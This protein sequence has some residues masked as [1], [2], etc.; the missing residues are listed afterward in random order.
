MERQG[1]SQKRRLLRRAHVTPRL[2]ACQRN[3]GPNQGCNLEAGRAAATGLGPK[4]A[5]TSSP[6]RAA[7]IISS[8]LLTTNGTPGWRACQRMKARTTM[9]G[10]S[11]A[12][13]VPGLSIITANGSSTPTRP[14]RSGPLP[15]NTTPP[16]EHKRGLRALGSPS[17]RRSNFRVVKRAIPCQ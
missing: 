16:T 8:C 17:L 1:H 11:L 15:P 13:P 10:R 14:G 9:S 4:P 6:Q 7:Q 5:R 12:L 3:E 2:G